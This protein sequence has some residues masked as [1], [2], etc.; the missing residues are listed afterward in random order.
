MPAPPSDRGRVAPRDVVVDPTLADDRAA[1]QI[2]LD[3]EHLTGC[4]FRRRDREIVV[5]RIAYQV[6]ARRLGHRGDQPV[7]QPIADDDHRDR[8][9]AQ[10]GPGG[11]T[12]RAIHDDQHRV[13]SDRAPRVMLDPEAGGDQRRLDCAVE[14]AIRAHADRAPRLHGGDTLPFEKP[15]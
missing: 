2:L 6:A 15:Q 14:R 1:R 11:Q 13:T 7:I 4:E 9:R 8:E 10:R 5:V 3:T 12:R